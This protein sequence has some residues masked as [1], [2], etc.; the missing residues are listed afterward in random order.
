MKGAK[1]CPIVVTFGDAVVVD[2]H[3]RMAAA[4]QLGVDD[5]P[6]LVVNHLDLRTS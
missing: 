1:M 6:A 5:V 3:A 4:L 2:G